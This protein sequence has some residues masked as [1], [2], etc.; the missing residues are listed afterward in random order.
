MRWLA[1]G[2]AAAEIAA[3]VAAAVEAAG[4]V[5]LKRSSSEAQNLVPAFVSVESPLPSEL[6]EPSG[7]L[8]AKT[9]I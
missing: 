1:Q 8:P 3:V 6:E 5:A 4:A 7:S 2:F 9:Q